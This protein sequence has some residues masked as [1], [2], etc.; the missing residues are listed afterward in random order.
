[1][2]FALRLLDVKMNID[3]VNT[4]V[5]THLRNRHTGSTST[6]LGL[7]MVRKMTLSQLLE[8]VEG[9][10]T[11]DSGGLG[12]ADIYGSPPHLVRNCPI[13]MPDAIPSG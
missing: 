1:M 7:Q 13:W 2:L 12:V 5:V 8:R 9:L 10:C 4:H 11:M 6:V 3:P